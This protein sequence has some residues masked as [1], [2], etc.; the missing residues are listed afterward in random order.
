MDSV[1]QN[2]V[3]PQGSTFTD[4]VV[5]MENGVAVDLTNHTAKM[6]VRETYDTPF[7]T[8][9]LD[10]THG[11]TLGADGTIVILI[12]REETTNLV[13]KRYLYDLLVT[14]GT[15]TIRLIEGEFIVTPGVTR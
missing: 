6:Q 7:V 11:L 14:I 10:N 2:F 5:Y 12:P 9:S 4:A 13:P 3:C 8:L 15:T 1:R